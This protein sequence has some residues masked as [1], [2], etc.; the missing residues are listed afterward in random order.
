MKRLAA[1]TPLIVLVLIMAAAA[2]LLLRGGERE[3]HFEPR[4]GRAA[5]AYELA[6]LE[7]EGVIKPDAFGGRPY[8][9]NF[10]ASWC[11]PCRAEHPML[12][13]LKQQG[14]PILG[15]AY[16]DE[17]AAAKQLLSEL[18]DPFAVHAQDREGRFA[19]DLG[20]AG[21]PETFVI[22]RDGRIVAAYRGPLT[23]DVVRDTILPALR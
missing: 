17:P 8:V 10:F 7:G 22:G 16:K 1:F 9:I 18:G 4:I 15:V 12:M 20:V 21:V 11:A 14:A 13:A 3:A 23:E 5:P 2:A 6:R 19:L